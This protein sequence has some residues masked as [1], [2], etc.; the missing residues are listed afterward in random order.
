MK[1]NLILKQMDTL[2]KVISRTNE[3]S[4]WNNFFLQHNNNYRIFII[5]DIR[6]EVKKSNNEQ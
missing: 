5:K 3:H 1:I 6:I 4:T 2:F